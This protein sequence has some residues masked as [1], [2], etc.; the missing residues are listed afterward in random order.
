MPYHAPIKLSLMHNHMIHISL[1]QLITL[2]SYYNIPNTVLL[3]QRTQYE[4]RRI[5]HIIPS[6]NFQ[7]YDQLSNI[8]AQLNSKYFILENIHVRYIKLSKTLLLSSMF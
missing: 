4:L 2:Y 6:L 3:L 8:G 5:L 7:I 1:L